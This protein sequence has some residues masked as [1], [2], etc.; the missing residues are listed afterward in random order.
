MTP[1]TVAHQAPL[2]TGFCRQEYW[3]GLPFPFQGIFQTEGLNRVSCLAGR[4]FTTEP[5]GN[6]ILWSSVQL[7]SRV[8]LFA[9]PWTAACQA[10]LVTVHGLGSIECAG[11]PASV[12]RLSCPTACGSL[13]PQPG[14]K[15]SSP[16][17]GDKFL[18]TGLPGKSLFLL[19]TD[20]S[21]LRIIQECKGHIHSFNLKCG[22]N[23][24]QL[25]RES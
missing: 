15:P 24:V 8:R 19:L 9:T 23:S 5:P 11:S 17:L 18:T 20:L 4:F 21:Y 3:N 10:A 1:W 2:S 12:H 7:L 13:V 16:A 6:P 25:T 14:M 22:S